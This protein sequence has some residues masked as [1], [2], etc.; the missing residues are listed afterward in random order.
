MVVNE[1]PD[2]HLISLV[3]FNKKLKD[4]MGN[5][6]SPSTDTGEIICLSF[7]AKGGCFTNFR[8]KS[9]HGITLSLAEKGRIE[10]YI[11]DRL[12]KMEN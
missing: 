3:P 7:H 10:N 6:Q 9:T 12:A 2:P 4:I 8:R 5:T 11:A 1:N